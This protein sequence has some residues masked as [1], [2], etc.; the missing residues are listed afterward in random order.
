MFFLSKMGQG[1]SRAHEG[2]SAKK[3]HR[4]P[5]HIEEL[6]MQA[7]QG[8]KKSKDDREEQIQSFTKIL[9][10][11]PKMNAVFFSV[12][13]VFNTFD[14][15]N[16]GTIECVELQEALSR[17][18]MQDVTEEETKEFFAE[19]DVY[20]DGKISF[21]EF[22]VCLALGYVLNTIP[23][24][25]TSGA[26][27]GGKSGDTSGKPVNKALQ[28][29][30]LSDSN[31]RPSFLMGEGPKIADAFSLVMD[32]Y[33]TFDEQGK[34][35]ITKEDMHE[36]IVRLGA[37]SPSKTTSKSGRYADGAATAF[38]TEERMNEMDW[39]K[40]GRISYSEFVYSFLGWVG[41]EDEEEDE[42]KS[43]GGNRK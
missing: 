23:A 17:L 7:I 14:K 24:L 30:K 1:N 43:G 39:D 8:V 27:A 40:T 32:A 28:R 15:D 9:L 38:L 16:S 19:V 11:A 5:T 10:T 41:F 29:V 13:A 33:L 20:E 18:T 35:Y 3:V 42:G 21:K 6:V 31:R 37:R 34:G 2:H 25:R 22:I 26:D 36:F 4:P 12:K